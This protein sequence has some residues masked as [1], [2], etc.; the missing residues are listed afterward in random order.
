MKMEEL[1]GNI[2]GSE[3]ELGAGGHCNRVDRV[4]CESG[5]EGSGHD[6][7]G[8]KGSRHHWSGDNENEGDVSEMT[9]IVEVAGVEMMTG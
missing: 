6:W 4:A 2:G 7:S 9:G 1:F 5:D 8:D 3:P